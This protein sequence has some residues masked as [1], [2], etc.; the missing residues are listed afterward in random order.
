VDLSVVAP[1]EAKVDDMT[2]LTDL[3]E[4]WWAVT[5]RSLRL[6][7][8]ISF[9]LDTFRHIWLWMPLGGSWGGPSFGRHY[10]LALEPFSSYPA[11]LTN[12]IE[13]GTQLILEPGEQR[14]AWLRAVAYDGLRRV[15]A[16]DRDGE[17]T[18]A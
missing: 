16:I 7:F 10:T 4:G 5:S 3:E 15:A 18:P 8:G 11:I 9:D 17:V 13:V 2:Y 1:P 12:A 14:S 6:G